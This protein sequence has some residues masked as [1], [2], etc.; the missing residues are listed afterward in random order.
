MIVSITPE[1]ANRLRS[2]VFVSQSTTPDSV[3]DAITIIS[4]YVTF[5]AQGYTHAEAMILAIITKVNSQYCPQWMITDH[6]E[7]IG[8]DFD[9]AFRVLGRAG[10]VQTFY[11]EQSAI[12]RI[13]EER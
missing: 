7:A 9:L 6:R 2:A 3:V 8:T 10:I 11:V 5:T 4:H 1:V 12:C 13:K